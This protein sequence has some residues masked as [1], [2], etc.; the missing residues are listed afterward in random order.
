MITNALIL[1]P[2][3]IVKASSSA[4]GFPR[5]SSGEIALNQQ[6]LAKAT[7]DSMKE[8]NGQPSPILHF[9]RMGDIFLQPLEINRPPRSGS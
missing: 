7:L 9:A 2:W 1:D 6:K 3:E 4:L 8:D 5:K